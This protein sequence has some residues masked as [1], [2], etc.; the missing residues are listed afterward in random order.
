QEVYPDLL[1]ADVNHVPFWLPL[2]TPVPTH[3]RAQPGRG[4][5]F[6]R[7]LFF[8]LAV[9]PAAALGGLFAWFLVGMFPGLREW[10]GL[11]AA[12]VIT[13][14]LFV[15]FTTIGAECLEFVYRALPLLFS[16]RTR[17]LARWRKQLAA[18]LARRHD[19][20]PGG[21]VRL[22]EDDE[23]CSLNLQ[24]FLAEHHVPYRLP[25]YD[26]QGRYLFAS[27]EKVEV[28]AGALL[29]AVGRGR[30][31]ELFVLLADL[32][33]LDDLTPLLRAVKVARARHHQ[34]V[35]LCPWPPGM[36]VPHPEGLKPP[37]LPDTRRHGW[38][39]T[40]VAQLHV[41]R[42]PP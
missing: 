1:R 15:A 27:P 6:Y 29:R 41:S 17:R 16:A 26:R 13:A 30:D 11:P 22:L 21:L 28:L 34:V 31:N 42:L 8:L 14:A 4:R 5:R 12:G 37:D 25:L 7:T 9:A 10:A 2:L 24:R 36:P 19:L 32:L 35:L 39:R 33:E 23:Q 3:A 38:L 18:L 20:G 40:A